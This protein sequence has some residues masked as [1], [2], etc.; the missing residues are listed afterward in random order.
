MKNIDELY[1]DGSHKLFFN[2]KSYENETAEDLK[3]FLHYVSTNESTD[4]FTKILEE[5]IMMTKQID[6]FRKDYFSWS[7]AERDAHAEGKAEGRIEDAVLTVREFNI[8]PEIV[9]LKFNIPLEILL[10]NLKK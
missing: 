6:K 7:L 3:A 4:D 5:K 9:A 1:V 10:E 2:A 8:A